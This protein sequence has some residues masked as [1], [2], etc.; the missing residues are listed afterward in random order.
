MAGERIF[1]RLSEQDIQLIAELNGAFGSFDSQEFTQRL[2]IIWFVEKGLSG[3]FRTQFGTLAR[4]NAFYQEFRTEGLVAANTLDREQIATAR[5]KFALVGLEEPTIDDL[6]IGLFAD[7]LGGKL[8]RDDIY[9][10]IRRGFPSVTRKMER[11]FDVFG[12]NGNRTVLPFG[13]HQLGLVEI[14]SPD[15][16]RLY[17]DLA[18]RYPGLDYLRL[19][20]LVSNNK[21]IPKRQFTPEQKRAGQQAA[22]EELQSSLPWQELEEIFFSRVNHPNPRSL[23]AELDY[24]SDG[25]EDPWSSLL[26]KYLD[27]ARRTSASDTAGEDWQILFDHAPDPYKILI[28]QMAPGEELRARGADVAIQ[29]LNKFHERGLLDGSLV[30]LMALVSRLNPNRQKLLAQSLAEYTSKHSLADNPVWNKQTLE[31]LF[32][33]TAS[34]WPIDESSSISPDLGDLITNFTGVARLWHQQQ[35]S[36]EATAAKLVKTIEAEILLPAATSAIYKPVSRFWNQQLADGVEGSENIEQ[37]LGTQVREH[38][39]QT[40][41]NLGAKLDPS[42]RAFWEAGT[43]DALENFFKDIAREYRNIRFLKPPDEDSYQISP[44]LHQVEA[45]RRL[46]AQAG[47]ILADEPGTGKTLELAIAGLEL[48]DRLRIGEQGRIL[49]VGSRGVIDNWQGELE[50]HLDSSQ[51]ELINLNRP[52]TPDSPT[53]NYQSTGSLASRLSGV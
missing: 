11:V 47:G 35:N 10:R 27:I 26:Q 53:G 48:C 12:H 46:I 51:F 17:E 34:Q 50:S 6:Y 40:I 36:G 24:V 42:V 1:G 31:V 32:Q 33:T 19:I 2:S 9:G 7:Q 29:E 18:G 44:F 16:A 13:D 8:T 22:K 43:I 25:S 3:L 39:R 49:V 23:S 21:G 52:P 4:A 30:P 45:C 20:N 14:Y 41:D 15:N 38:C 5:F 28:A 37:I